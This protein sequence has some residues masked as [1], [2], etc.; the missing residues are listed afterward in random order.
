MPI[1]TKEMN[2]IKY[3]RLLHNPKKINFIEKTVYIHKTAAIEMETMNL[4]KSKN[5]SYLGGVR[6]TESGKSCSFKL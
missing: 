2:Y 1:L 3:F 4:R 6:G 5:V